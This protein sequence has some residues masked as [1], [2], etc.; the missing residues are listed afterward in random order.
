[1]RRP[2]PASRASANV[3][4]G[5]ETT[6]WL[7]NDSVARPEVIATTPLQA[8]V[9]DLP[10]GMRALAGSHQCKYAAESSKSRLS[11]ARLY[12]N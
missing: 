1:M 4:I 10:I 6:K 5:R 11:Q 3:E 2:E 12:K 8:L 7:G 9:L